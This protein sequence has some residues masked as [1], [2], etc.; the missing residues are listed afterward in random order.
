MRHAVP[1]LPSASDEAADQPLIMMA[2]SPTAWYRWRWMATCTGLQHYHDAPAA[3][4]IPMTA[5]PAL[6]SGGELPGMFLTV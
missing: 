2:T 3:D 4:A 6:T 1:L 5:S